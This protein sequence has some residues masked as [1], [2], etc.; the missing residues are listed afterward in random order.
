MQRRQVPQLRNL[1]Q[2]RHHL[3][4]RQQHRGQQ[5]RRHRQDLR[6]QRHEVHQLKVVQV[7]R[8]AVVNQEHR[9]RR[10]RHVL[11]QLRHLVL[12]LHQQRNHIVLQV[13]AVQLRQQEVVL[14]VVRK[15]L[16]REVIVN[17]VARHHVHPERIRVEADQVAARLTR[18]RHVARLQVAHLV[19]IING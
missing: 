16:L 15:V 14:L 12:R 6:Q 7:Q 4:R 19:D 11:H 9:R 17:Q 5:L 2:Q 8:I 10:Q 13:A 18:L 1:R 3:V